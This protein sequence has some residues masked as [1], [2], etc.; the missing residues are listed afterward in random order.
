MPTQL[1]ALNLPAL[2]RDVSRVIPRCGVLLVARFVLFIDD[3]Q[4]GIWQRCKHR[5]ACADDH[6][7]HALRDLLPEPMSLPGAQSAVKHGNAL[8]TGREPA[9]GLWR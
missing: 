7:G 8:E 5:R 3:N 6:V 4:T 1:P 9:D 2:D